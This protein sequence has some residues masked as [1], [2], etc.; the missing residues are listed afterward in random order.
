MY[1]YKRLLIASA[2]IATVA[3]ALFASAALA[4]QPVTQT[5]DPPPPPWDTCKAAGDGAICQGG[6]SASYGLEDTG[7]ACGSGALAFD[8]Y[9]RETLVYQQV[10]FYGADGVWTRESDWSSTAG[11]YNNPLTGATASY[12]LRAHGGMIVLGS[13]SALFFSEG[14]ANVTVPGMGAVALDAGRITDRVDFAA[15]TDQQFIA[16]HHDF[17]A[18]YNGDASALQKLCTALSAS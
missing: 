4:G 17:F 14:Q 9:G 6:F 8:I 7:I 16:G 10:I 15:G 5:L 12:T 2:G 18:Y 1:T 11:E 3:A 13:D